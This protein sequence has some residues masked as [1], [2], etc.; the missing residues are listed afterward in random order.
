VA[1]KQELPF[2][3]SAYL[4]TLI[5]R[6]LFQRE[7]FALVELIKNAYDSGASTVVI[8]IQPPSEREP[9][10]ITV[11]DDG[12]GM[13]LDAFRQSFM[14][15]GYSERPE[16]VKTATRVPTGEKGVGRFATDRLGTRLIVTTKT[17]ERESAL[18]VDIDWTK[19][20]D[21]RK[22]FS[23]VSAP[24]STVRSDRFGR[25]SGTFL[26]IT[27]LRS[28]W[29]RSDIERL[30]SSLSRL[31]NPFAPPKH[32]TMELQVPGSEKLS[33]PIEPP[34]IE[35]PDID[36]RFE[37]RR[38]G[39]VVRTVKQAPGLDEPDTEI[40]EHPF[41]I[42]PLA[43]M[44][45]RLLYFLKRPSK[46]KV[47]GLP[48]A[49]RVYRD[50]FRIEPFGREG[51]DWLGI[52]AQRAKRAGHAHV[53]PSRLFGFVE[54][55]RKKHPD[56]RDVTSREA[57]LDNEASRVLVSAVRREI[58]KLEGLIKVEVSEPRWKA[59][60]AERVAEFER[61]RLQTLSI[62]SFGLAHELR[63]P[64]QA[65]ESEA[66]NIKT[67][68]RELD[69]DDPEIADSEKSIENSVKRIDGNIKL[70]ASISSGNLEG[71][72]SLDLADLLRR[73]C[74]VF[75]A[76][77]AAQGIEFRQEIPGT[78]AARVNAPTIGIVLANLIN[79]SIDALRDRDTADER[80]KRIVVGLS[81]QRAEHVIEVSD[82]GPGIP[83]EIQTKIFKKFATK[84]TGGMGVGLYH[85]NVIVGSQGG[86][87]TFSSRLNV[88]T[89]FTV[90]FPEPK[91]AP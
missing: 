6:E 42:S 67:R 30:R 43:G 86:T 17:K 8:T 84:K 34:T 65:I 48:P 31:L 87:M 75:A 88:G 15:A 89:T 51:A 60:Q 12:S 91:G 53:V 71:V 55:Q 37:L 66:D 35:D 14:F 83:K 47:A 33:G 82:T 22:R 45:G 59:G 7:D 61:A 56:L 85:C 27:N 13:D 70:I 39:T 52:E 9:G 63:Q 64:L 41:D 54:T 69:I 78:Q 28:R 10:Q 57:L 24:F 20:A 74:A 72:T 16:Q 38:D 81:R 49:V 68:L 18:K 26:E 1:K 23:D 62:M 21:R 19:F 11:S 25:G 44:R 40:V 2:E 4:Q 32:F 73:D 46:T 90:R 58:D 80:V 79:N 50:G 36:L 29:E 77:A 5:G 76:R 3:A